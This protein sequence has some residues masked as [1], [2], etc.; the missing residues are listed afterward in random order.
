MY[1]NSFY[2]VV[3]SRAIEEQ[4][5][6][7]STDI[8]MKIIPSAYSALEIHQDEVKKLNKRF[9]NNFLVGN[10]GE[11]DNKH[12]GQYYLIEAAKRLQHKYPDIHFIFLGK[13]K[14][15]QNYQEQA[16]ELTN[17][18]FEGFVNN[19]GDYIACF[20]LFVFPSLNEGLGS[21]LF[22]VMQQRVPIIASNVG[23][24]PDIITHEGN[25]MLTPPK[26]AHA[27]AHAIE[28]LY[29]SHERREKLANNA[30]TTIDNFS[31]EK[32]CERYMKL[33]KEIV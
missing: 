25:G 18:T 14:D 33:Y 6:K 16:K 26:D 15:A 30:Y 19:V 13:G 27:I 23:G 12:K 32:M 29:K 21:I 10:I 5:R 9:S 11:L 1:E 2:T 20:D 24:I 17:I 3:L 4:T 31:K 7:I 28:E 8:R 22:D